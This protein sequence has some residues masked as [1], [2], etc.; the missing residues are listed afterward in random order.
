M[1]NSIAGYPENLQVS[2]NAD[3][4]VFTVKLTA[5]VAYFLD[6]AAFPTFFAVHKASVEAAAGYKKDADGF[7]VSPGAWALKAGFVSSGPFMLTEWK[8]NESM[9]Y[10]RILISTMLTR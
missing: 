10:T 2:A 6:L 8:H 9:V 5:P 3:G 7:V 1:F 4:S